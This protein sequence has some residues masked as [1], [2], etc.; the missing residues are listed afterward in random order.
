MDVHSRRK[1]SRDSRPV[2]SLNATSFA[3]ELAPSYPLQLFMAGAAG[4][5]FPP[6]YR[7]REVRHCKGWS[8]CEAAPRLK[9]A[10]QALNSKPDRKLWS[11]QRSLS[12][13]FA[14]QKITN[15]ALTSLSAFVLAFLLF[16]GVPR[17]H[18]GL[19]ADAGVAVV[20]ETARK[21][22]NL[23]AAGQ[24]INSMTC[25]HVGRCEV[26]ALEQQGRVHSC[27]ERVWG[28]IREIESRLGM[29]AFAV[30]VKS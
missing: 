25:P 24:G 6:C 2:A 13:Q 3:S 16:L 4:A 23:L 14:V 28:A 30:A 15:L 20:R 29:N 18:I 10:R 17:Q 1:S 27:G 5:V 8:E 7:T 12:V 26:A 19:N 22:E 21:A 11:R 9:N